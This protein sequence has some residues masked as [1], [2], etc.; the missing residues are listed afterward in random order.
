MTPTTPLRGAT[1]SVL[2]THAAR[3]APTLEYRSLHVV[4]FGI[5]LVSEALTRLVP[6]RLRADR[7]PRGSI[8]SE[9]WA[10]ADRVIPLVFMG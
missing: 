3:K 4:A 7:A 1:M 6:R 9:A 10:T 8:V 2:H 5:F